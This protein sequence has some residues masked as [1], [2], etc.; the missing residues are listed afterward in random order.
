MKSEFLKAMHG[1]DSVAIG[2]TVA[3]ARLLLDS[4]ANIIVQGKTVG[5][6]VD[7]IKETLNKSTPQEASA[8]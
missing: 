4:P 6:Y 8:F 1:V 2:R 5:Y 3:M 7:Q